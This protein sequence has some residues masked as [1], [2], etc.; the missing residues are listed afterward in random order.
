MDKAKEHGISRR[1]SAQIQEIGEYCNE[2]DNLVEHIGFEIHGSAPSRTAVGMKEDRPSPAG[3][4][5][6]MEVTL[7]R[8]I[9]RLK[10]IRDQ[11]LQIQNEL[12]R[13]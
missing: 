13:G 8:Y 11:L 9:L 4:L 10:D 12:S 6:E 3:F 5:P 2:I 7:D 1:V